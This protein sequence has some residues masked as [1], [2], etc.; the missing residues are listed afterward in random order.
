MRVQLVF[1]LE[2]TTAYDYTLQAPRAYGPIAMERRK[3]SQSLMRDNLMTWSEE[4]GG[5]YGAESAD[6]S[7]LIP[8]R[9]T[10]RVRFYN[11]YMILEDVDTQQDWKNSEVQ[12]RYVQEMLKDVESFVILDELSHYRIELPL[13]DVMKN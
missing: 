2:N 9:Q 11:E 5:N 6:N 3:S 12:N 1:D 8:A 4:W 13:H 10:V 7:I